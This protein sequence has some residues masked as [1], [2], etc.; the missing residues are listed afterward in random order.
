MIIIEKR[1]VRLISRYA[2]RMQVEC[3]FTCEIAE[4]LKIG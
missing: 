2:Y 4:E 3:I 1:F